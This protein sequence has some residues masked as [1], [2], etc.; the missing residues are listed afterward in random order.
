MKNK[1]FKIDIAITTS[2]C[3]LTILFL[4]TGCKKKMDTPVYFNVSFV[5]KYDSLP[6]VIDIEYRFGEYDVHTEQITNN[7]ECS[8]KCYHD[9]RVTLK[10]IANS[11]IKSLKIRLEAQGDNQ[12]KECTSDNCVIDLVNYLYD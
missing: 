12:E 8:R 10:A 2:F 7:W 5:K 11:N 1:F 6:C 9:D 3:V 4:M